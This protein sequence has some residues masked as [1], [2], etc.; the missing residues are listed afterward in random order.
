MVVILMGV[1]ASGKTT[2]GRLLASVLGYHFYDADDFH[3]HSNID[4]M[5]RGIPLDDA[6]RLPWLETLRHLVCCCVAEHADAV[7]ACSA[8][9]EA[10]QQ[11]LLVD[12]LVRLV[13]L[14]ADRDLIRQRLLQRR[15]HFMNP[16][17]LESQFATLE[18]PKQ[19]IWIDAQLTPEEIVSAIRHR[20]DE[21][22]PLTSV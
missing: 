16:Q 19:G 17:L 6:D 7:L 18:E 15:G 20:L 4:K 5:R 9:K 21:D 11:F 22:V 14:R 2:V 13:Y 12:P 10:Y 1:T 8:L 3:P